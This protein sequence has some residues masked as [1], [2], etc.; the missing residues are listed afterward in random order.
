MGG[1]FRKRSGVLTG[2][3]AKFGKKTG[4]VHCG[5][6]PLLLDSE[7]TTTDDSE[8]TA[9]MVVSALS[10]TEDSISPGCASRLLDPRTQPCM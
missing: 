9:E 1:I 6:L 7:L 5:S 10:I 3:S 4:T 2:Y 8:H